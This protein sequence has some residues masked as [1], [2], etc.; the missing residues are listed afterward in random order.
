MDASVH[1]HHP[2]MY[3]KENRNDIGVR[4]LN[5]STLHTIFCCLQN[6]SLKHKMSYL[7]IPSL[8]NWEKNSFITMYY[9]TDMLTFPKGRST[10]P[11]RNCHVRGNT[12]NLD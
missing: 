12:Q 9:C 3:T 8:L 5:L 2:G 1:E 11:G 10:C 7:N 4:E 6:C